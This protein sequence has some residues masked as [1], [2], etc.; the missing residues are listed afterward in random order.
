MEQKN[1]DSHC[2]NV[3][4]ALPAILQKVYPLRSTSSFAWRSCMR[5]SLVSAGRHAKK[6]TDASEASV[7]RSFFHFNRRNYGLAKKQWHNLHLT[8]SRSSIYPYLVMD[9]INNFPSTGGN[10][11][12]TSI[13]NRIKQEAAVNNARELLKVCVVPSS[14]L[15]S[16]L[17]CSRQ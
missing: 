15:P 17:S 16:K 5:L 9:T 12:K 8:R 13:M 1:I 2:C 4:V 7:L 6:S 14:L 3:L 11:E 10:S